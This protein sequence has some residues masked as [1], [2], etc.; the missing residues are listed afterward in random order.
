MA[1]LYNSLGMVMFIFILS[2]YPRSNSTIEVDESSIAEYIPSI[3]REQ[4]CVPDIASYGQDCL[5]EFPCEEDPKY[6]F[7]TC[8]TTTEHVHYCCEGPCEITNADEEH[9]MHYSCKSGNVKVECGPAQ[10]TRKAG[11]QIK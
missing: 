9:Y 5:C 8:I 7:K 1:L 3:K 2:T 4:D 6:S 11:R 10:N